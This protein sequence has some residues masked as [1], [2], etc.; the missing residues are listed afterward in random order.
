MKSTELFYEN[1]A[2]VKYL[3]MKH[4]EE[5]GFQVYPE[6]VFQIS[7]NKKIIVDVLVAFEDKILCFIEVKNRKITKFKDREYH[8]NELMKTVQYDNYRHCG[9][10]FIYCLNRKDIRMAINGV[11]FLSS[12]KGEECSLA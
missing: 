2:K 4:L 10:P 7:R 11:K 12:K 5:Y 6:Q 1:E 9:V 8:I 3:L